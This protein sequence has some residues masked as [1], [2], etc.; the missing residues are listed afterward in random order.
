MTAVANIADVLVVVDGVDITP[1][2][3]GRVAFGQERP[4][5]R[6]VSLTLTEK[7]GGDA[8][9][10]DIV[11]D[12][13]DGQFALPRE[14]VKVAVSL[15]WRQ[16][17]DVTV[18]MVDKGSFIVDEVEHSGP[19][20]VITIRARSAD[21]TGDI[22]RRRD[23]SWHDTTLGAVLGQIANRQRLTLRCAPALAKLPVKS[24]AQGRESDM[25][26]LRRL[27]REH[28]AVATVKRGALIFAPIGAATTANG[29]SL[30]VLTLRR[31]DGDRHAYRIE[32]REEAEG[33]T[34]TWHD[35]AG[36]TKKKV[37][38]GKADGAKRLPRT[39][40]SEAEAKRAARAAA[41]RARREP[42]S[43]TIDLPFGRPDARP[44]APVKVTGYKAAIDATA[45]VIAE[46]THTFTERGL[47]T[48]LKLETV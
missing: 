14:G 32:K 11:I 46:A 23:G 4:R 47:V 27:G 29:K 44:E 18:G 26:L 10:L 21:M 40:A 13:G 41:G 7:R 34:A 38:V 43:M 28:D 48:A 25:A 42:R 33:V 31:R 6:L 22:R 12:D 16:G 5:P 37:T 15:G 39:Y 1:K 19:P 17:S 30:P 3:K 35:R 36:A 45:W 2:L 24:L 8:D 9:Q 20:D